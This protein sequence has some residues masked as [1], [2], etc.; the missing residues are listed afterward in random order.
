MNGQPR[1][2]YADVLGV[3]FYRTRKTK[4]PTRKAAPTKAEL[5][6]NSNKRLQELLPARR[7]ENLQIWQWFLRNGWDAVW[8]FLNDSTVT[9]P[10]LELHP[11]DFKHA[12]L[13]NVPGQGAGGEPGT[14]QLERLLRERMKGI[15]RRR[16]F[17]RKA[18]R[19]ILD[20]RASYANIRRALLVLAC[21]LWADRAKIRAIYRRSREKTL[22]T[23]IQHSVDHIVPLKGRK[24]CGLHVAQNLRVIPILDNCRKSNLFS[25]ELALTAE[26]ETDI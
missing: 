10:N 21:P 20:P 6:A 4:Q 5:L 17:H 11:V 7:A 8:N 15:D 24:V 19:I 26:A 22:K 14:T 1:L 18:R 12:L 2:R 25:E 3:A 9:C 13:V 16:R 23:G